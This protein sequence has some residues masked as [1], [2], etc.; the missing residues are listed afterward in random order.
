MSAIDTIL[1]LEPALRAALPLLTETL[2]ESG[3]IHLAIL[4][5]HGRIIFANRVLAEYLGCDPNELTGR[6]FLG[7][8]TTHDETILAR[9]ISAKD[10]LPKTMFVLNLVGP[11]RVPRSL[12][13]RMA[14]IDDAFLLFGEPPADKNA[15]TQEELLQL[16]NQ[17]A[18]L[19]R[20]NA[21]QGRELARALADLKKTQAILVHQ[22]K[23]ASLGQMTAGIAH[24]INNPVAFVLSNEQILKR[25]FE[26]IF[27]FI[28]TVG[29]ALPEIAALSPLIHGKIVASAGETGLEYLA[30]AIP[31][32][33]KANMEGLERVKNIVID[34]RNFSRLDEAERK[35][36]HLEEGI[37]ASL[38]F[39]GL[40]IKERG[41]SVETDFA[42]LPKVLCAPGPLNQAISNVLTNAIQASLPGQS[43]RICTRL[44]EDRYCIE[45]TD[46]GEGISPDHLKKVFDPFFTTRPVGSGTG[47]GLSIAHQVV[48]AHNGSIHIDS[49]PGSGTRVRILI[50]REPE[51]EHKQTGEAA[52]HGSQ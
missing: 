15:A 25:D 34:L 47:L 22:E 4:D 6:S 26:D 49:V 36:C 39:L 45:V 42:P 29:D 43:I 14:R 18:V 46:H 13:C 31:R 12:L 17:L 50:P 51:A 28:N 30:E 8:L 41:V 9:W 1:P 35:Y 40:L 11:D 20:E 44:E 21:R 16:N 5:S 32:K 37:N 27:E 38:R 33:I 52:I 2:I 24:E 23:M 10:P 19:S 3:V 48:E 7:S